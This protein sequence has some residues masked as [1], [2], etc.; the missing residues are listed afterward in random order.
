MSQSMNLVRVNS[1]K[2]PLQSRLKKGL[3]GFGW[4]L[5]ILDRPKGE[6]IRVE[7]S[8]SGFP[9]KKSIELQEDVLGGGV[10]APSEQ[11]PSEADSLPEDQQLLLAVIRPVE[12]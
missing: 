10:L 7:S 11:L 9:A 8:G 3:R 2:M 5:G 1:S 6:K 4:R 12:L